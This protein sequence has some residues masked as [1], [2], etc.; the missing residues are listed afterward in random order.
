MPT[1]PPAIQPAKRQTQTVFKKQASS[2]PEIDVKDAVKNP[3]K[4]LR[5]QQSH[6]YLLHSQSLTDQPTNQLITDHV[7]ADVC[8]S[9]GT[10]KHQ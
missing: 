8:F 4:S 1:G 9:A 3:E 10:T 7:S 5:F 2:V 6:L